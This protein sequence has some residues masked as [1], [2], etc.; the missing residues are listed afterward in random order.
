MTQ[1]NICKLLEQRKDTFWLL[2]L[3]KLLC[4]KVKLKISLQNFIFFFCL[5]ESVQSC[6][7]NC[8]EAVE[9]YN[10]NQSAVPHGAAMPL[11]KKKNYR[12]KKQLTEK[13]RELFFFKTCKSAQY[14]WLFDWREMP[15]AHTYFTKVVQTSIF[16]QGTVC[17]EIVFSRRLCAAEVWRST[18]VCTSWRLMECKASMRIVSSSHFCTRSQ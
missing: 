12:V 8:S 14:L 4:T 1:I 5:D 18:N 3:M 10:I 16:T 6:F 11:G 2:Q 9:L 7:Q 15:L 13:K 17:A